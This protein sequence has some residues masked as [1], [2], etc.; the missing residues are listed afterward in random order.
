M[1]KPVSK[2]Y[3]LVFDC[4]NMDEGKEFDIIVS[5]NDEILNCL[6]KWEEHQHPTMA[7]RRIG[8][9]KWTNTLLQD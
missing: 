7:N 9:W 4:R 1:L 6:H 2:W 8:F 3:Q 5:G